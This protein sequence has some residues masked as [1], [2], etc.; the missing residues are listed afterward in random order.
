[1]NVI[2]NGALGGVPR[3][4]T[5]RQKHTHIHENVA[6]SKLKVLARI[7]YRSLFIVLE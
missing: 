4:A 6:M 1:M 5:H 2:L 3:K 7:H